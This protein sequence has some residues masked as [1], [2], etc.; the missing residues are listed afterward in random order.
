MRYVREHACDGLTVGRMVKKV[1]VSRR[2]L[3]R[4]FAEDVGHSPSDEINRVRLARV[5]ALLVGTDNSLEDVA[6]VAGFSYAE[7]MRRAFKARF[8]IAPGQYRREKR[9]KGTAI[10]P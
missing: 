1:G 3:E 8:G 10:S 4:L 9:P 5:Q 6:R 2:T 7:S